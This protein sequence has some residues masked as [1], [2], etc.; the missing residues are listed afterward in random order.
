MGRFQVLVPIV[1]EALEFHSGSATIN[2]VGEFILDK[3]SEVINEDEKLRISWQYDYRWA[4]TQLRKDGIMVPAEESPKGV[5]E[6]VSSSSD[7]IELTLDSIASCNSGDEF[8]SSELF[9]LFTGDL[10]GNTPQKGIHWYPKQGPLEFI[11]ISSTSGG[12]GKY[13]D[14][15]VDEGRGVFLYYLMI[16]KRHSHS[17]EINYDSTENSILLNQDT[18]GAPVLLLLREDNKSPYISQGW[19]MM[20]THCHD[21][22]KHHDSVDSILLVRGS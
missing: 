10:F 21:D 6:L 2:Q 19:F 15:Y 12:S 16:N 5:W 3:Y 14:R 7:S 9:K 18:N 20:E 4:A 1:Q 11:V 13:Q 17:S 22:R 8:G